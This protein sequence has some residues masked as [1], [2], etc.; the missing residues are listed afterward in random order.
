MPLRAAR[1]VPTDR[2]PT[3]DC[4]MKDSL[5]RWLGTLFGLIFVALSLLVAVETVV[6]KLFNFSLQGAD[7]LGAYSL[8]V[9]ATIAFSLAL[10]GRTH[11]RVDVFHERLPAWLQ[12]GLN[13]LS[14]VCMAAFALLLATLAWSIF[15]RREAALKDVAAGWTFTVAGALYVGLLAYALM[16]RYAG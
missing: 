2:T 4:T 5:E 11:I 10:I 1:E 16:L 3:E 15:S 9:C 14:A 12:T 6:R 7:E 13:W 8:A